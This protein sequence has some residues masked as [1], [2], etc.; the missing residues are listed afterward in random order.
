MTL[1]GMKMPT[2]KRGHVKGPWNSLAGKR[3]TLDGTLHWQRDLGAHRRLGLSR[4][5]EEGRLGCGED[6]SRLM[7]RFYVDTQRL[8]QR[9]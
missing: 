1:G 4:S 7:M 2:Q 6:T 5:G 8:L 9:T 3:F